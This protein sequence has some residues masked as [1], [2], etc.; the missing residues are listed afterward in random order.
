MEI[1]FL[2]LILLIIKIIKSNLIFISANRINIWFLH[3]HCSILIDGN[4]GIALTIFS[5]EELSSLDHLYSFPSFNTIL[6]LPMS[7]P[8]FTLLALSL[9]YLQILQNGLTILNQDVLIFGRLLIF[10]YLSLHQACI[11]L[12]LFY[13]YPL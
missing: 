11:L 1:C 6:I 3:Q 2:F 4:Y 10:W 13:L 5:E 8:T 9:F 12:V 7:Q